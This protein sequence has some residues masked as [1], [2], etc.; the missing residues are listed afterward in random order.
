MK[1]D[2]TVI[3]ET[4]RLFFQYYKPFPL[5]AQSYVVLMAPR[6]GSNLLCAALSKGGAGNP[7]E[8]FHKN[9]IL[10]EEYG[11]HIDFNKPYEHIRQAIVF[12]TRNNI[13]GTKFNWWQFERFLAMVRQLLTPLALPKPLN[14]REML[15][16]F[17]PQAAY[18]H[19]KRHDKVAQA[20][21]FAKALQT[22]EWVRPKGHRPYR[23]PT[24]Q[25][26]QQLIAFSLEK[27][28]AID[29]AWI[30][31]LR[32]YEVPHLE[33]WYEDLTTQYS[34]T[35]KRVYNYLGVSAQP[36]EPPLTKQADHI[37]QQW[38]TRFREETPWLTE[39]RFS[40]ALEAKDMSTAFLWRAVYHAFD[41]HTNY[42]ENSSLYKRHLQRR[43]WQIWKSRIM[44]F[45]R[46]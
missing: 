27:M 7:V 19:I 11:W 38:I 4:R 20:V 21:S 45:L 29:T 22:G 12:Q 9:K 1:I 42:W 44:H 34:E 37:S 40:S 28:L 3:T 10:Q 24:P 32:Q 31:F 14:E 26:D 16:L 8:A 18:I 33:I 2:S 30:T 46:R 13:L 5:P 36:P 39:N 43:R 15:E 41:A 17:F 6:S 25:Y 35:I 23:T